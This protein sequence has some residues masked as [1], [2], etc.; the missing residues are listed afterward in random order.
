[1]VSAAERALQSYLEKREKKGLKKNT[2]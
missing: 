2:R 1:L